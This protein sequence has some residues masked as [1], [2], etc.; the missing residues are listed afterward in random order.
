MKEE[1]I[2]L[3]ENDE[4]I[5][6]WNLRAE[7][8][9]KIQ[10]KKISRMHIARKNN[11]AQD[12]IT[13]YVELLLDDISSK[14]FVTLKRCDGSMFTINT[15]YIIDIENFW[16]ATAQL[17][18]QSNLGD[19]K[20]LTRHFLMKNKKNLILERNRLYSIGSHTVG[21]STEKRVRTFS[22]TI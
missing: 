2:M 16:M 4:C 7:W 12:Y 3:N 17:K 6:K 18:M 14:Q 5:R 9:G 22:W 15:S 20:I 19:G 10:Y 8:V 13:E 1:F 21:C 11:Q